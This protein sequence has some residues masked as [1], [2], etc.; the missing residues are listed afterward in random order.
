M[1]ILPDFPKAEEVLGFD[2]DL[3]ERGERSDLSDSYK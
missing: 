2:F 1:F 3:E